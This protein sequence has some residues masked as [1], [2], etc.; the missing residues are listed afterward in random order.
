VRYRQKN[1]I[2]GRVEHRLSQS[3]ERVG[4]RKE[5]GLSGGRQENEGKERYQKKGGEI[6]LSG[7]EGGSNIKGKYLKMK[8]NG[9]IITIRGNKREEKK[10]H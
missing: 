9:S 8:N 2:R 6:G 7:R 4:C 5:Y 1:I 10:S 3:K